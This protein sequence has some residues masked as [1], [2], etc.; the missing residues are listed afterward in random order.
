VVEPSGT[1]SVLVYGGAHIGGRADIPFLD[2]LRL[3]IEAGTARW[4]VRQ[5]TYDPDRSYAVI[6]DRSVGHMTAN[7][8]V[9][10]V[11][12]WVGREPVCAHVSAGGGIYSLGF[13]RES[14]RRIGGAI[15][16]GIGIPTGDRGALQADINLHLIST[17]ESKLVA[18]STVPAASLVV[19]WVYRFR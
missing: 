16:A 14:I 10:L 17:D 11:G 3:R 18:G 8:L 19:G 2:V 13:R 9:A 15:A 7:H 6:A 5:K 12:L 4:D 1:G